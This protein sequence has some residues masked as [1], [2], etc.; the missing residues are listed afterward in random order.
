MCIFAIA[1]TVFLMLDFKKKL[2]IYIYIYQKQTKL[3][4]GVFSDCDR[5]IGKD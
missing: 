5:L 2:Y 1:G 4:G 3:K